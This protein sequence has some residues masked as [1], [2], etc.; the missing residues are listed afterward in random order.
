MSL[1]AATR[2]FGVGPEYQPTCPCC[3]LFL[4]TCVIR[5][6][7]GR[8]RGHGGSAGSYR[9]LSG[10]SEESML[11]LG[12]SIKGCP[13]SVLLEHPIMVIEQAAPSYYTW[14]NRTKYEHMTLL[15]CRER[16]GKLVKIHLLLPS[17]EQI[18]IAKRLDCPHYQIQVVDLIDFLVRCEDLRVPVEFGCPRRTLLHRNAFLSYVNAETEEYGVSVQRIIDRQIKHGEIYNYLQRSPGAGL[19]GRSGEG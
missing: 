7:N 8:T 5:N 17:T 4:A 13:M 9:L 12:G 3:R 16:A 15:Q 10:V 1:G 11:Y 19:H 6:Q 18:Y 2:H 14:K